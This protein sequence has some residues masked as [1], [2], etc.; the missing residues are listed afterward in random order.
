MKLSIIFL[1]N[2]NKFN[3]IENNKLIEAIDWVIKYFNELSGTKQ[4]V[5]GLFKKENIIWHDSYI[6]LRQ[7]K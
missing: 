1:F 2:N 7:K 5:I 3:K 6:L 4:N